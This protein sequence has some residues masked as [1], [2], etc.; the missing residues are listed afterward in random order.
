L[1][2]VLAFSN[3]LYSA[4]CRQFEIPEY[5]KQLGFSMGP[6]AVQDPDGQTRERIGLTWVDSR[7]PLG[8]AGIRAGDF[9]RMYHGFG[10]FCG[11]LSRLTKGEPVQ[12]EVINVA[13]LGKKEGYRRLVTVTMTPP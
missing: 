10:D 2:T 4:W 9:P 5:E 3:H 1:V 7:G 13:D 11:P 8:R 6:I 12:I